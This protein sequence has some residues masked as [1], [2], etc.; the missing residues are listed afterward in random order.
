MCYRQWGLENVHLF[1]YLKNNNS[2]IK[3]GFKDIANSINVH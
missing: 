1:D 2:I 3:N